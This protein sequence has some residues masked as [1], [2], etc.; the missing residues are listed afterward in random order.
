MPAPVRRAPRRRPSVLIILILTT[1]AL[2]SA[3][4]LW[5]TLQPVKVARYEMTQELE[6]VLD[7]MALIKTD[8]VEEVPYDRMIKGAL[9]GMLKALDPYSQYLDKEAYED[10]RADTQGEFGGLGVEV[11]LKSGF[12]TVIAPLD[13]SPAQRAGLKAGDVIMKIDDQPIKDA[14]L[15]DAVVRLRGEPGSPVKLTLMREGDNQ[16]IDLH[17]TRELIRVKSV[18]DARILEPGIGYL[19]LAAFQE[20]SPAEVER[21]LQALDRDGCE[22]LILDLR[23]NAGGLL[24]AAA[25]ITE[26]LIPK[27]GVVFTTRGRNPAKNTR[28]LS[29][30]NRPRSY[31]PLVVLVNKGSA[32]GSEILAGAVQDHGLGR[33][34]GVKTYG[35]GSVQ[36][37]L[38]LPDGNAIRM[39]TSY[40]YTPKGRLIHEKGIEPDVYVEEVKDGEDL[41]LKAAMDLVRQARGAAVTA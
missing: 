4:L 35:K 32:S 25:L 18:K 23:N 34:V 13:D 17:V 5:A 2:S 37:L 11:S 21:A 1:L 38:G 7:T 19:R 8:Y 6:R 36:T 3:P 20:R 26:K 14:L 10:L 24:E 15:H 16:I 31:A 22:A 9:T 39:T 29:R 40:Y 28:V 12:L 33:V 27:G 30:T 41:P